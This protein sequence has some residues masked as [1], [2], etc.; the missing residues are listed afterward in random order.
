[1]LCSHHVGLLIDEEA[2]SED[3]RAQPQLNNS[4]PDALYGISE[5]QAPMPNSR[6]EHLAQ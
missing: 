2:C 1:V 5:C 4:G 6:S 3:G